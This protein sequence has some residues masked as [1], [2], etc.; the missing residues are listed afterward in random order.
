M[1]AVGG[2]RHAADRVDEKAVFGGNAHEKNPSLKVAPA[3]CAMVQCERRL[4]KNEAKAKLLFAI[5]GEDC[6]IVRCTGSIFG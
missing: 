5:P 1:R 2:Y 3:H 4:L 6:R